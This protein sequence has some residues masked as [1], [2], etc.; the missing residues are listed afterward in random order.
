MSE[1]LKPCP[2]CGG[3]ARIKT[4]NRAVF[5]SFVRYHEKTRNPS[6]PRECYGQIYCSKCGIETDLVRA[7]YLTRIEKAV[8]VWNRRAYDEQ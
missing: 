6:L 5:N 3:I 1:K 4:V 8:Y 7:G 2:F